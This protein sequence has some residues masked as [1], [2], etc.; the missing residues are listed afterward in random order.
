VPDT[1]DADT[2]M[3]I[4]VE[5]RNAWT[6]HYHPLPNDDNGVL[7]SQHHDGI[8]SRHLAYKRHILPRY[9]HAIESTIQRIHT[10]GKDQV[11]GVSSTST[12]SFTFGPTL[13]WLDLIIF[14]IVWDSGLDGSESDL[15]ELH[16]KLHSIMTAVMQRP[17]IYDW[18]TQQSW[19]MRLEQQVLLDEPCNSDEGFY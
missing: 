4:C 13:T 5:W 17:G 8:A 6:R 14:S 12:A 1:F 18:F 16:P 2:L 10:T 11:D 3:E 15:A 7:S 9:M 19:R